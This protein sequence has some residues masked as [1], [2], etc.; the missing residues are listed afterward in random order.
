MGTLTLALVL[1]PLIALVLLVLIVRP[2]CWAIWRLLPDG[3]VRRVLFRPIAWP[4]RA[5]R[6]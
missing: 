4:R 5:A 3:K 2:I 6:R 1:R